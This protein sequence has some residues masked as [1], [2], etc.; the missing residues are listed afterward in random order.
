MQITKIVI[1]LVNQ[2]I[3]ENFYVVLVII[4]LWGSYSTADR[5]SKTF[6]VRLDFQLSPRNPM[7]DT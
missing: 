7:A 3:S 4:E 6:A 5:E 2:T 1:I